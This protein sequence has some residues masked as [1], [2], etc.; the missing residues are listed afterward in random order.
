MLSMKQKRFVIEYLKDHNATKAAIRAGYSKKGAGV[1]GHAL[2]KNPN[3]GIEVIE[4]EKHV[5]GKL[6]ITVERVKRELELSGFS[7]M[8]HYIEIKGRTA[9]LDLSNLTWDQAAAIQEFDTDKYG[10]VKFK[11]ANKTH[12]LELLGRSLNMFS[13][14]VEIT[15][16]EDPL[17]KLL[18][19]FDREHQKDNPV[20]IETA[21]ADG[22]TS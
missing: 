16:L 5:M 10:R 19:A 2:L 3:V 12:A 6:E 15:G 11:L 4:R 7:N 17:A 9:E 22:S 13:D 8:R 21:P 20:S 14:R 18:G 1:Q